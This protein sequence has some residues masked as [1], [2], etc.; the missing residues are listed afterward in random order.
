MGQ[1]RGEV[2]WAAVRDV[3]AQHPA[4]S[5]DVLDVGGG[6]GGD[7][8]R[9]A[10]ERHRV[11]VVDPNADALASLHRRTTEAGVDVTGL[12]GDASDLVAVAGAGS[13]D[14]VLC[15]EVLPLLDD[16]GRALD[17]IATVLRPG[18]VLSVVAP[19]RIR[20]AVKRIQAGELELASRLLTAAA[21]TWDRSVLG[22]PSYTVTEL[23]E[24]V[25]AHGFTVLSVTGWDALLDQ[26]PEAA[27]E[28][29]H[30]LSAAYIEIER[31]ASH[32][33]ALIEVS[34]GLHCIARID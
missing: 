6:T 18:G 25:S 15:H 21:A 22:P 20:A 29:D 10:A 31:I 8:V 9:M 24:L 17:A 33:P 26:V 14:V 2:Q 4:G 12:Q 28:G 27:V 5:L 30:R 11:R 34:S 3:F 13:A 7:A 16:P 1:V 32:T 19:G 23:N